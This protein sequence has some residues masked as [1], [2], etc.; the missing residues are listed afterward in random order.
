MLKRKDIKYS[1]CIG[2]TISLFILS[3]MLFFVTIVGILPSVEGKDKHR[4]FLYNYLLY[5]TYFSIALFAIKIKF[6]HLS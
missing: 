5:I 2:R 1:P 6:A 4:I 3:F